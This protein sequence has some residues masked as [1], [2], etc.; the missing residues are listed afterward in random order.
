MREWTG[1]VPAPVPDDGGEGASPV[2]GPA[3][4]G[5]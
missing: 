4:D 5:R 2:A 3:V 1:E